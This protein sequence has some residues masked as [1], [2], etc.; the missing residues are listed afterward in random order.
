[1]EAVSISEAAKV[2]M[3]AYYAEL[4]VA[5]KAAKRQRLEPEQPML[6]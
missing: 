3:A 5:R 2:R 6:W 1:M 4:E